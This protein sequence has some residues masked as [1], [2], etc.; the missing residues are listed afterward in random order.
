MGHCGLCLRATGGFEA[1][2]TEAYIYIYISESQSKPGTCNQRV[3]GQKSGPF[4]KGGLKKCQLYLFPK[5]WR[6]QVRLVEAL[7]HLGKELT[8]PVGQWSTTWHRAAKARLTVLGACGDRKI[9][10]S[11]LLL[12]ETQGLLVICCC[13]STVL[14][15]FY[16]IVFTFFVIPEELFAME[17]ARELHLRPVTRNN[18]PDLL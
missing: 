14:V 2:G 8:K 4:I 6:R 15:L 3:Q 12:T 16:F 11:D 17:W 1:P 13:V 9:Y 7:G 18:Y 10:F 5:N